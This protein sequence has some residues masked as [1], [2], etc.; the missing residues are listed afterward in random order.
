VKRMLLLPM[1][2]LLVGLFLGSVALAK[3]T[4]QPSSGS[5]ESTPSGYAPFAAP[6]QVTTGLLAPSGGPSILLA[7]AALLLGTG[8]L[9]CTILTRRE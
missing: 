1:A 7:G 2:M 5:G 6:V 3:A 4:S 9:T 8:V